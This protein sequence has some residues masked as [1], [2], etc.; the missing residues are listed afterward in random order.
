M[1]VQAAAKI[2]DIPIVSN[3]AYAINLGDSHPSWAVV[4]GLSRYPYQDK[5]M[6]YV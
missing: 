2:E 4:I 1:A 3:C 5:Y 6:I